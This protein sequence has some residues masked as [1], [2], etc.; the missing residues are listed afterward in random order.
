MTPPLLG[1]VCWVGEVLLQKILR[2]EIGFTMRA[3]LVLSVI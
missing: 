2:L 1:R 3:N